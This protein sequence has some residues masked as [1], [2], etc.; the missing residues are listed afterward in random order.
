MSDTPFAGDTQFLRETGNAFGVAGDEHAAT[1]SNIQATTD[2]IISSAIQGGAA[3]GLYNAVDNW[4]NNSSNQYVA[5]THQTGEGYTTFADA[6]EATQEE[7]ASA[8]NG[9]A[10]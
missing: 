9:I 8:F 4:V 7:G 2:T 5:A 6:A 1:T 10:I 3:Q